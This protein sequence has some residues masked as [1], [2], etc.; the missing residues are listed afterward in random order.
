MMGVDCDKKDEEEKP[1]KK[2]KADQVVV[3]AAEATS[4]ADPHG[5]DEVVFTNEP[6]KKAKKDDQ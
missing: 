2:G 1:L 4:S 6:T 3:V 5:S